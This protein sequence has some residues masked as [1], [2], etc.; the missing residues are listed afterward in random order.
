MISDCLVGW[1]TPLLYAIQLRNAIL[2][3]SSKQPLH[4]APRSI[5]MNTPSTI[6][7]LSGAMP[8]K[9]CV[10]G[11]VNMLAMRMETV[12]VKSM[13]I[14]SKD[15]RSLL[16]SWL[17]PHRGISQEKLPLYLGFFEF[18]HNTKKRGLCLTYCFVGE[19]TCLTPRPY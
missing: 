6:P 10:M 5:P 11:R 18:V 7:C 9:R 19:P 2:S 13:S 15:E 12:C 8:T 1:A 17:P 16:R 14:Q 4:R 3:H